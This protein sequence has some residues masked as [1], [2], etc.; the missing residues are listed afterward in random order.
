[1]PKRVIIMGAAGRDFHNF[2]VLF[3]NNPHYKVV[4]FTAAQIPEIDNRIYPRELAGKLY[5]K[6]I[7]IYSEE[8][9]PK[10]IKKYKVDEVFFS[11]SDVSYDYVMEKAS[12]VLSCGANLCMAGYRS[13]ALKSLKPVISVCA[14]RTGC[15]KSQTTRRV[16]EVLKSYGL[17]PVV[18][19]HPMPYGDLKK[20][21]V[22]KF[23]SYEDLVKYD[24]TIEEREEY[25]PHIKEGNTVYAGIDYG[26]ILKRAEKEADVIVWD[27]G[28]NDFPFLLSNLHIVVTDPHRVGHELKYYP[29]KA[30][31]MM[32]DVV[33]INKENTSYEEDIEKLK[34]NIKKI[35]STAVIVDANSPVYVE[36]PMVIKN[37]KVLVIEDGPTLTH[38]DMPFGAGYIAAEK[39]AKRIIDPRP[40]AVGSIK[41]TFEKYPHLEKVLPAVGY[42]RDQIRELQETINR[43]PCDAVVIGTPIDISR[44]M[45]INKPHT[46]VFYELEE[47]G[48]PNLK[49][50][51]RKFLQKKKI[52]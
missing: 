25:E 17:K 20:Q 18:L 13:T 51:I 50:I 32:A 34:E 11:Y 37:K 3:R 16:C 28:N 40:Y 5:P 49:T 1:M 2:N 43:V 29:G 45:L 4:A 9:L 46:R 42:S 48:T 12:L 23:S 31:L 30:N 6:G 27:G 22:Q 39:F 10:L 44:F 33:V 52:I 7:K 19:R 38:G 41:K 36:D 8:E 24:C 26:K 15:G 35:N 14:V 21:I 47:I